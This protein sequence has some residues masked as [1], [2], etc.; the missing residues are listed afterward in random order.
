MGDGPEMCK[1]RCKD[2]I[3]NHGRSLLF[4]KDG[5]VTRHCL[6]KPKIR[7]RSQCIWQHNVTCMG[8]G[9]CMEDERTLPCRVHFLA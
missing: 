1:P 6:R 7:G 5:T 2:V 9:K 3:L 4:Q 8:N